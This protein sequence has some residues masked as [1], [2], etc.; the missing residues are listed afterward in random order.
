MSI[1]SRLVEYGDRRTQYEGMLAWDDAWSGPRPGILVA[2]TIR[3]RTEFEDSK[4]IALA[5]LGFAGFALDV[6]G[7]SQAPR[8]EAANRAEMETLI[9]DRQELQ[10]RLALS[11]RT[12]QEQSPVDAGQLAAIGFCFGGLCVLDLARTADNLAAAVSFHGLLDAPGKA[13]AAAVAAKVLVLHG[14]NDPLVPPEKVVAFAEEMTVLG[15]DWQ[16]HAYGNTVHA[17]TNPAANDTARGTV[18]DRA[19]DRRS[20][21]A[22]QNLLA[23][24]FDPQPER[25]K[26]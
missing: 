10:R 14:W 12:L 2:H 17:F 3:G 15:A 4:A 11:L 22:L 21:A 7:A 23:E 19:A 25:E 24:V 9:G 18:Y 13:T 20:W 16:L 1:Q 6:Y 8:D 26:K 5:R